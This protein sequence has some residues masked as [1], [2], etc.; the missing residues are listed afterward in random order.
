MFPA[1]VR[2]I[3][4]P[5]L[6]RNDLVRCAKIKAGLRQR[7]PRP[8]SAVTGVPPHKPSIPSPQLSAPAPFA[9]HG[10]RQTK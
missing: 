10:I 3:P 8:S 5:E 9:M 1:S 4:A 7:A 2:K 6:H